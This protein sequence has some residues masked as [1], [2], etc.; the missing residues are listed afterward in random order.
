MLLSIIAGQ[1]VHRVP[2]AP[3]EYIINNQATHGDTHGWHWDDYSFALVH[4]V[5][6]PDPLSG[7]RIEYIPNVAWDKEQSGQCIKAALEERLITSMHVQ[8]GETYLMKT[9]TTMH[10][11]SPL[12]GNTNRIA[13]IYSFASESDLTDASIE[14]ETMEAI[15]PKDTLSHADSSLS[16]QLA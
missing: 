13:I 6:S 10:R 14:H 16:P 3:E 9:N 15:Y 11:V 2:Y 5:E 7:G 4:V 12:L 8:A 1:S